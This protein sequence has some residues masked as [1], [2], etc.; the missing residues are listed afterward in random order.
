MRNR[1][2]GVQVAELPP[3]LA[4]SPV[5][6]AEWSRQRRRASADAAQRLL[7]SLHQQGG[8]GGGGGGGR[9]L[10]DEEVRML[11]REHGLSVLGSVAQRRE[12]LAEGLHAHAE[13]V[14]FGEVSQPVGQSVSQSFASFVIL[15]VSL[16]GG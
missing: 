8:V 15:S 2:F 11:L 14:G 13:R 6:F 9:E 5:A 4:K 12:R 7:R 10:S 1:L 16:S 3:A